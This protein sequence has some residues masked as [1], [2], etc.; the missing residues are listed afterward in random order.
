M[1]SIHGDLVSLYGTMVSFHG[2]TE[3]F[4]CTMMTLVFYFSAALEVG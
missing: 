2:T 1:V 4:C 3:S